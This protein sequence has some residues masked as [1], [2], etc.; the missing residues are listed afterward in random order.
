[1]AE[2]AGNSMG[3]ETAGG[4]L[5]AAGVDVGN[6][7]TVGKAVERTFSQT[8]LDRIV[9]ERVARAKATPPPDYEDLKNKA[10]EFDK[11]QEAQ[12]TELERERDAREKAEQ[13][14]TQV[15]TEAKEIRLR[16]AI[17]AEAAKPDRKVVDTD[18][19]IALLDRS[20]LELDDSGTPTN[21]AKAMD[22]LLEQRPF[23]VAPDGGAR[24]NADQG[25]RSPGGVKQVTEAELK[26]MRP[27]AIEKAR[28]EGRLNELLGVR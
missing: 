15:E 22:S 16:S 10:S 28:K 9:Q 19:V 23:L 7:D 4:T 27:E 13:R 18:A 11:L 14:A 2:E 20:T 21:I 1:M 26:T 17:L 24:G 5:D 8:E 25:A 6:A 12:K 3:S